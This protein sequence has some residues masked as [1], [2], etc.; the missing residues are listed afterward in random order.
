MNIEDLSIEELEELIKIKKEKINDE[1]LNK[2]YNLMLEIK[3]NYLKLK[4]E[5]EKEI[6]LYNGTETFNK[7]YWDE[8]I[9]I[10][11]YKH[12]KENKYIF[13]SKICFKECHKCKRVFEVEFDKRTNYYCNYY[14]EECKLA[15]KVKEDEW[16]NINCKQKQ[17]LI[18]QLKSMPY[19]EYLQ[20]EHWKAKSYEIKREAGFKCQKCGSNKKL[21]AHHLTY[22]HRGDERI[23]DLMCLCDECH[24]KEHKINELLEENN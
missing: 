12:L 16:Y 23:G 10:S 13:K 7:I 20:T 8:E 14:C 3:N 22:E 17:E 18:Q 9:K 2:K 11:K 6:H 21:A 15:E 4:D 19:D 5:I 1:E 24:K